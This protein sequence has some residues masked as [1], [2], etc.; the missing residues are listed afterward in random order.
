M[1]EFTPAPIQQFTCDI[2]RMGNPVQRFDSQAFNKGLD[3]MLKANQYSEY[4]KTSLYTVYESE[5]TSDRY[6]LAMAIDR[7]QFFFY[8]KDDASLTHWK[9]QY[10]MFSPQLVLKTF[11]PTPPKPVEGITFAMDMKKAFL[12]H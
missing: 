8:I 6:L 4:E 11:L 3:A 5:E 2:H 10:G 12:S 1:A 9:Q 7:Y